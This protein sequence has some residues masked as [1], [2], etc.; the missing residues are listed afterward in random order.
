MRTLNEMRE[1]GINP[2]QI[3]LATVVSACAKCGF[4]EDAR[5]LFDEMSEHSVISWNTIIAGYVHNGHGE[6][7]LTLFRQMQLTD[8]K[9]DQITMTIVLS[10][11]SSVDALEHGKQLHDIVIKSG[12]ESNVFVGSAVV[13]MYAKCGNMENAHAVFERMPKL[14]GVAWNT[15]IA[16]YSQHAH[17][18]KALTIFQQM[19]WAGIKPTQFTFGSILSACAR[20]GVLGHGKQIHAQIIKIGFESNVFAESSLVDMYSKCGSIEDAVQVFDNMSA[21]NAVS[22]NGMIMGYAHN[23]CGKEALQLFE[24]MIRIDEKPDH[25]TFIG[26]LS[27]CNHTGLV[28]EG[29]HYFYSMSQRHFITPQANHYAC[30]IDLLGR[31]GRLIDAEEFINKMPFE[32]DAVI[33]GTMLGACRTQDNMELGRRA[34]ECL[35]ELEPENPAPYVLLSH[36]YA[37]SGRWDDVTNLRTR[38]KVKEIKKEPGCSWIEV[39]S[40]VHAFLVE[41][42]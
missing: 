36:I 27:A 28:D 18:E 22:W 39:K 24:E 15:L 34:A 33:W 32:P 14:D 12:L 16:G 40:R 31:A 20:L 37:A 30:I 17:S 9:T 11:C 42:R 3:T 35:L 21:R 1:R 29:L 4:I 8:V 23:G 25:A 7:A 41:D 38:M 6:E 19:Q 13:D 26:V 2:D 5:K 10:A